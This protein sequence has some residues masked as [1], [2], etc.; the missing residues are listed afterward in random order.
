MITVWGI[1]VTKWLG[2]RSLLLFL[3]P[4]KLGFFKKSLFIEFVQTKHRVREKS[5]SFWWCKRYS[6]IWSNSQEHSK[7]V[8]TKFDENRI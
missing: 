3:A 8:Y 2:T 6:A 7:T 1:H 5:S 4:R